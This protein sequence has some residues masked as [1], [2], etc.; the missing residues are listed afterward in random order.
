[1]AIVTNTYQWNKSYNIVFLIT[2]KISRK[3]LSS[4]LKR[5]QTFSIKKQN[6]HW[7]FTNTVEHTKYDNQRTVRLWSYH[8]DGY[9]RK[10]CTRI[11]TA[12]KVAIIIKKLHQRG[13]SHKT[14]FH[15]LRKTFN[16]ETL[17]HLVKFKLMISHVFLS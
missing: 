13:G 5:K 16:T 17:L 1:M 15:A 12:K 10:N 3:P 2:N 11:I 9:L 6:R 14:R 4:R 8:Q 7:H